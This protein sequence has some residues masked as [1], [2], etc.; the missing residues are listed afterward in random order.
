[1]YVSDPRSNRGYRTSA[2]RNLLPGFEKITPARRIMLVDSISKRDGK[3]VQSAR[4]YAVSALSAET[5]AAPYLAHD[6]KINI[7][8]FAGNVVSLTEGEHW[9]G[10]WFYPFGFTYPQSVQAARYFTR[11]L[12]LVSESR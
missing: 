2:N 1:M 11:N 5:T 6:G 9:N 7:A 12:A 8:T 10:G 3:P 4:L